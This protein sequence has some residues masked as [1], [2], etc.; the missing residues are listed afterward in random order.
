M[1]F[2][3]VRTFDT[4][5][6]ISDGDKWFSFYGSLRNAKFIIYRNEVVCLERHNYELCLMKDHNSN[7]NFVECNSSFFWGRTCSLVGSITEEDKSLLCHLNSLI[8]ECHPTFSYTINSSSTNIQ[9]ISQ[10]KSENTRTILE[11]FPTNNSKSSLA[12]IIIEGQG[13]EHKKTELARIYRFDERIDMDYLLLV[14]SRNVY[15][16]ANSRRDKWY[17]DLFL[18]VAKEFIT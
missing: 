6:V 3:A 12:K 14:A 9:F 1:F 17:T 10:K 15:S 13:K 5:D 8:G 11:F 16:Y 2:V 4:A 7:R 18:E